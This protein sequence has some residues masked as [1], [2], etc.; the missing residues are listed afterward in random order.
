MVNR[1]VRRRVPYEK[2]LPARRCTI[3][4]ND[5]DILRKNTVKVDQMALVSER[6]STPNMLF[7]CCNGFAI[8]A[9]HEMNLTR[10]S[11]QRFNPSTFKEDNEHRLPTAAQ[12]LLSLLMM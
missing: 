11:K 5:F 12:I 6:T 10:R 7:I 2:V 1:V 9:L 3:I 4:G 8:V